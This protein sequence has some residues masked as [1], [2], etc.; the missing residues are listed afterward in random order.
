MFIT[1][2]AIILYVLFRISL[3]SFFCIVYYTTVYSNYNYINFFFFY[4][5]LLQ[6]MSSC[7]NKYA[8]VKVKQSRTFLGVNG[9]NLR[10]GTSRNVS[11]WYTTRFFACPV[12]KH[13]AE[14]NGSPWRSRPSKWGKPV[15]SRLR[16][17][18]LPSA[19]GPS[20]A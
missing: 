9:H 8:S 1:A 19:R 13:Y 16:C 3:C 18:C 7:M 5:L 12:P 11:K 15:C 4:C 10:Q 17:R 6:T 14:A 20:Q 2:W